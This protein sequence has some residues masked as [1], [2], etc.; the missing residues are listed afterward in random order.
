MRR[1][2]AA[3][4]TERD[5]V[6]IY[7]KFHYDGAT[8]RALADEYDVDTSTIGRVVRRESHKHVEVPQS[9]ADWRTVGAAL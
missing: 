6:I 4:L 7:G 9:E 3:K 1:K 2:H 8:L 5:V